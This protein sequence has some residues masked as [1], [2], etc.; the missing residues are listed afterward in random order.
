M[1]VCAHKT[2]SND[3][4]NAV[5][6]YIMYVRLSYGTPFII[7]VKIR[8]ENSTYFRHLKHQYF[9]CYYMLSEL[10]YKEILHINFLLHYCVNV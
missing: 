10:L 1:R 9:Y 4:D 5:L 8:F 3:Q 7:I 6:L 2:L